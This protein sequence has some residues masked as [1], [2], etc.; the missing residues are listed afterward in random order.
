MIT[1]TF[2]KEIKEMVRDGRVKLSFLI[3]IILLG[4]TLWIRIGHYQNIN[5]QYDKIPSEYKDTKK[6][7][8]KTTKKNN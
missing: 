7:N 3:V 2:I 1:K 6:N 5:E 8:K 4:V